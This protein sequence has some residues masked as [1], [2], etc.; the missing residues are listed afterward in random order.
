MATKKSV[1]QSYEKFCRGLIARIAS[2]LGIGGG[3]TVTYLHGRSFDEANPVIEKTD[4]SAFPFLP[5]W[6]EKKCTVCVLS[7]LGPDQAK[8]LDERRTGPNPQL[9]KGYAVVFRG[10]GR[11]LMENRSYVGFQVLSAK[12]R[13]CVTFDRGKLTCT[14]A[15]PWDRDADR[16]RHNESRSRFL[17][18]IIAVCDEFSNDN[19]VEKDSA[20][21]TVYAVNHSGGTYVTSTAH[22]LGS[23]VSRLVS[24][25]SAVTVT[26]KKMKVTRTADGDV[27]EE[28]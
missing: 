24:D 11:P 21:R 18:K 3:I 22:S 5:Y 1:M 4:L 20:V 23:I 17:K 2:S 27:Y 26:R 25:G 9:G 10:Y 16:R 7:N 6:S 15:Y 12:E 14:L 28:I 13:V 8:T 19:T